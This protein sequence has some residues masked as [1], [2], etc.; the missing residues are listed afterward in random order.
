D[1]AVAASLELGERRVGLAPQL[2]AH[3]REGVLRHVETERLLLEPQELLLLEFRR[4]DGWMV[5]LVRAVDGVERTL[6]QRRLPHQAVLCE[7]LAVGEGLL[8]HREHPHPRRSGRVERAA[9]H[10]RLQ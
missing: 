6:E 1:L 9:L 8:E 7:L 10:E 2:V 4:R 3:A 5:L